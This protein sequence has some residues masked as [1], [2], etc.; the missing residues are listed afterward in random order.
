LHLLLHRLLLSIDN[1]LLHWLL[2]NI[3]NLLLLHWLLLNIDY[4]LLLR[5]K[6]WSSLLLLDIIG[7]LVRVYL[8]ILWELRR[9]LIS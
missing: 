1:L 4:L 5:H 9:N 7:S 6:N 3:D 8:L 2:L